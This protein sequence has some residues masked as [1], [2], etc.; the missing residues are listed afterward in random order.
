MVGVYG[1]AIAQRGRWA[2]DHPL[3]W[4]ETSENLYAAVRLRPETDQARAGRIVVIDDEDARELTVPGDARQGNRDQ[5]ARPA[6]KAC[7]PK[8]AR[9]DL[10]VRREV[11]FDREG[12][13]GGI[14][15]LGD[16]GHFTCQRALGVIKNDVH[17]LPGGDRRR[18]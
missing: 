2:D 17:G 15:R 1:R 6:G 9:S 10:G 5:P 7:T 18:A 12:V 4:L 8:H 11:N 3:A 16:L 14:N 13:R